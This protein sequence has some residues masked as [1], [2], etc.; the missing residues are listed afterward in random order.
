MSSP[1]LDRNALRAY[2]VK[3]L[4]GE[5][6]VAGPKKLQQRTRSSLRAMYTRRI[7][8]LAV[9]GVCSRR[10][11]GLDGLHRGRAQAI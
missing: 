1:L 2:C 6:R 4:I 8:S 7:S 5:E 3:R 11:Q 10:R 9:V